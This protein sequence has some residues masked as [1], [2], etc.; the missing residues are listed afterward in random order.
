MPPGN[1]ICLLIIFSKLHVRAERRLMSVVK[2]SSTIVHCPFS[3]SWQRLDSM[4][5]QFLA[6]CSFSRRCLLD[7]ELVFHV[8]RAQNI[9]FCHLAWRDVEEIQAFD[10]IDIWRH[11]SFT[12]HLYLLRSVMQNRLVLIEAYCVTYDF[13]KP[14]GRRLLSESRGCFPGEEQDQVVIPLWSHGSVTEFTGYNRKIET[15]ELRIFTQ[16]A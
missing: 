6:F 14:V 4:A 8:N 15:L 13:P 11:P 2:C 10:R 12:F 7:L 16:K 9:G 5:W 3:W 1:F